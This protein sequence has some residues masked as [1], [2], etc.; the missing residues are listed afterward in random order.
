LLSSFFLFGLAASQAVI[1]AAAC[2]LVGM[3][4]YV[5]GEMYHAAASWTLSYELAPDHVH[6][7]YQGAFHS[8]EACG[9]SAAPG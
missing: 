9:I 6:G 1:G 7:Q 3:L 5:Y 2:L 8:A 4:L